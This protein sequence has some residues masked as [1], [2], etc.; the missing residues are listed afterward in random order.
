MYSTVLFDLDGTLLNTI[1]DLAAAGNAVCL[2]NGWPTHSIPQYKQFVGNGIPTL[3]AR[4][5]PPEA[6]SP[7]ALAKTLAAF[8]AYYAAHNQDATAPYPGIA[9]LLFALKNAGV[10]IGVVTNKSDAFAQQV[11]AHYFPG[12]FS[13]VQGATSA[14][15]TKP[16]PDMVHHLLRT[17]QADAAKPD[18][19][20]APILDDRILFVGDSNVD[21]RTAKNAGLASCGVSWGFRSKAELQAEGADFIAETPD[22]LKR[23]ILE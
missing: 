23:I 3:C 14:L 2:A 18:V 22:E 11:V 13:Y 20:H 9:P 6:Q 10:A 16:A 4:F 7:A 21:I 19:A 8:D 5:S 12:V 1:D 15:P 17:M